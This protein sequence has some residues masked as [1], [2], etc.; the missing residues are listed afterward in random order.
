MKDMII[1]FVHCTR[2][3]CY[4]ITLR[5]GKDWFPMA[6]LFV[7]VVEELQTALTTFVILK[8]FKAKQLEMAPH[9]QRG[10]KKKQ[11]VLSM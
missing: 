10:H 7:V 5:S 11:T 1:T 6:N 9:N 2:T 4:R 8:S 3:D